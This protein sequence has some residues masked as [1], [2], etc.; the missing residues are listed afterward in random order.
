MKLTQKEIEVVNS[1]RN[2]SHENI[3]RIHNVFNGLMTQALMN[4]AENE[5]ILIPGFG[6]FLV[7]YKGDSIT[8]QGREANIEVFFDASPSFKENIGA[9]ED[10]KK[11]KN[12]D[13]SKI[14]IIRQLEI[15]QAQSLRM[16][17]NDTLEPTLDD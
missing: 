17:M 6:T 4:Y 1:I 5:P 8:A 14:P 15:E 13:M 16:T 9:Y 3:E 10:F 7:R 2:I 12:K 11:S